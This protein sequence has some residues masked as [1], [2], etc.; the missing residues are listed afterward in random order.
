[1]HALRRCAATIAA[2]TLLA[3]VSSASANDLSVSEQGFEIQWTPLTLQSGSEASC[4]LTL[5]GSFHARSF[6]KS[7]GS[8]V[9]HITRA[10]S[11]GCALTV[12]QETLPWHVT[13]LN[14]SGSLPRISAISLRFI[15]MSMRFDPPGTVPACLGTSE[16]RSPLGGQ[17]MLDSEGTPTGVRL[18]ES[19][20]IV[21]PTGF[22]CSVFSTSLIGTGTMRSPT[23]TLAGYIYPS[24]TPSPA[25]F[26]R[27]SAE[28]LSRRTLTITAGTDSLTVSS[29]R[30]ANGNYF[31]ITDPNRCV[32][33]II[34]ARATCTFSAIL[35]APGESGRSLEDTVTV[36]TTVRR[37]QATVRG[38]T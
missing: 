11:S 27:V 21:L 24:L 18:T 1:M 9:G 33:A 37:L 36:E 5:A 32:G 14:F 3:A 31:A 16:T 23:F 20:H 19:E 38:S 22:G 10:S 15:G 26:G 30:V 12:L 4:N 25:E 28:S 17:V 29:I 34:S 8:L 2:F 6:A 35:V 13:Y 7:S